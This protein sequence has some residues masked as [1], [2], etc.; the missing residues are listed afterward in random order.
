MKERT[1]RRERKP[2]MGGQALGLTHAENMETRSWQLPSGKQ[3]PEFALRSGFLVPLLFRAEGPSN[4]D[5]AFTGAH[6]WLRD[7]Q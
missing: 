1:T 5:H 7:R 3:L 4:I 2:A 6:F